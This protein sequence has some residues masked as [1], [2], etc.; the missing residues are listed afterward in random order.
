[1]TY[2]Y[3]E[4][5]QA[6]IEYFG[7]EELPANVFVSKYALRDKEGR[8]K[9]KTPD[10]MHRRLAK[11]FA[12]IEAK[13][14]KKPLS[15]ETI[16]NL[17][18]NFSTIIPQGSPIY[19]I[20]N[21]DQYV[22]VSNCFVVASPEDSY[23][24]IMKT[25]EE[26]AQISKRRGGVGV[27]L[28]N[29]RPKGS[30]TQNSSRSSTGTASWM[31]RFSNTIREVGQDGRR[32]ALMESISVHHPD[33]ETFATIKNDDKKVTGANISIRLT[34]EFLKAVD[35]DT[36]YEQRW[37]VDKTQF[38]R[39]KA[40]GLPHVSK[41][42]K[43]RDLWKTI[44]HSAWFRAEPGLLFWDNIIKDSP[45]D[46]YAQ[47]GFETLSTNPCG[48][49]PLSAYDSCRL[50]AINLF[51]F[52]RNPFT[53]QAYFDYKAFYDT[54][55]IAQRLMDDLVDLELECINRILSKLEEDKEDGAIKA[56]E[57]KLWKNIKRACKDG[58]RTGLGITVLGD[59]LAAIGHRYGSDDSIMEVERIYQTLKFG[60]YRSSVDMAK[61][62]G[63]FP[64]WDWNL[65]KDNPFINRIKDEDI[66]VGT[67]VVDGIRT[68]AYIDG[69]DLFNDIQKYGR[70]NIANLTT[71]P[72]GS[73]SIMAKL[74]VNG[75]AFHNTSSGIEP[76]IFVEYTRNKKGN[77]GDINFRTDYVDQNGDHWMKFKVYHSGVKAWMYATGKTEVDDTC[78]YKGYT[79]EDI[80]W[81]Q[82]VKL[83]AAAQKHVDHSI[84]STVNLPNNVTEEEVAKI[85]ETGWKSGCKGITVYRDGCRT[86]VMVKEDKQE[87]AKE[88]VLDRPK[89]LPCDVHHITV[90]GKQYFVL[91]G[92]L[93]DKPYEVF[94]GKNGFID[95]GVK[96]G[97]IIKKKRGHYKCIFDDDTELSPITASCDEHEET[98]TRLTSALLRTGADIHLVVQQLERVNGEMIGFAKSVARSLKKYVKDGTK[99]KGEICPECKTESIIR[100]DGCVQ[101]QGCGW[102]KCS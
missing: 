86:G 44:I 17:F 50:L 23:G 25:D 54:A 21:V 41:Q 74:D 83:Q 93:N 28:S 1:M 12:R 7:G 16:Y 99:E 19:G 37:P 67:T 15:E 77:P 63:P 46:C 35:E 85:Y 92:I 61:E 89:E 66:E 20:G 4:A 42:V 39:H 38:E 102:S 40:L 98:I 60:S 6:S 2:S 32:G 59:T 62:L 96:R 52:V 58:R 47:F 97:R 75:K 90:K 3:E 43:A 33:V 8:F 94:A 100:Q 31:E 24:G 48:E 10:D 29:L 69:E 64:I 81:T 14:F 79:S 82:R 88:D 87:A 26:L 45:A 73:I 51:A 5:L 57:I 11:E 95:K 9:E 84:S 68:S 13:K 76:A 49:I 53:P 91:V 70:R 27:D 56:R 72:T 65:E 22:S 36:Y 71:A 34:D 55:Q 101:C 30:R 18:K 78:P 80:V